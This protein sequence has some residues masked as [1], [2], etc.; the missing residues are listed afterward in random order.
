MERKEEAIT[1]A[2][3]KDIYT[4]KKL[5]RAV[6]YAHTCCDSNFKFKHKLALC[7]PHSYIVTEAQIKEARKVLTETIKNVLKANK[8]NLLFVGMGMDFDPTIK[9][10]VGNHRIRTEFLNSEGKKY[11]IEFGTSCNSDKLRIDQAIDRDKQDKLNDAHDKQGEFYNYHNL[12]TKT[13]VLKYT[14]AN[15]I[16]LINEHFECNFS[17]MVVDYNISPDGVLCQSL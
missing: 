15:V 4:D 14:Y 3:F 10:G 1:E 8:N 9:D 5:L 6:A 11:F 12:E 16:K 2:R 17:K 13:P 7:W